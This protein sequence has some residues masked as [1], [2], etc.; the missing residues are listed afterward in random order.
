MSVC[1]AKESAKRSRRTALLY[2][3]NAIIRSITAACLSG[4]R[5]TTNAR[6]A[7]RSGQFNEWADKQMIAVGCKQRPTN[8]CYNLTQYYGEKGNNDILFQICNR[9][10][11]AESN[12]L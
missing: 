2:G 9:E 10:K 12:K 5:R 7:N 11:C 6:C 8:R 1:D 3:A 4:S